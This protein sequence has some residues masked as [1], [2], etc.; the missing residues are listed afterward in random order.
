[1]LV[2]LPRLFVALAIAAALPAPAPAATDAITKTEIR[3]EA[4][5][6]TDRRLRDMIWDMFRRADLRTGKPPQSQ[7]RRLWFRTHPIATNIPNLCRFDAMTVE[8]APVRHG[9]THDA[10][11]PVHPVALTASSAFRFLAP[12]PLEPK[13]T[14]EAAVRMLPTEGP[15]TSLDTNKVSF[16]SAT[17]EEVAR[18][19]Y[20]AFLTLQQAL[21]DK[22]PLPLACDLY[23]TDKQTCADLILSLAQD[24]IASIGECD[25][26]RETDCFKIS[27][28]DREIKIVLTRA[29]G[30]AAGQPIRAQL[31]SMIIVA[32]TLID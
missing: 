10:D 13:E 9:S 5:A 20:E 4:P 26:E 12:P 21:R 6:I 15:C 29:S 24:S 22:K 16:F 25:A 17:S 19:G 8:F 18:D 2:R 30:D 31:E 3:T 14:D 28:D 27:A 1:M 23:A 11:T 32:D 7:L